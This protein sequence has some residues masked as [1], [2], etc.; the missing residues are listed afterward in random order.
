MK[1]LLRILF[2]L[3]CYL[4][5]TTQNYIVAQK[6]TERISWWAKKLDSTGLHNLYKLNDSIYRSEQPDSAS[7]ANLKKIGIKS[8]LN[9]TTQQNDTAVSG[10]QNFNYY[11][12]QMNAESFSNSDIIQ[13]LAVIRDAPKPILIHCR[14]GS[15]RTGVVMAM[16]RIIYENRSKQEALDELRNGGYGFNTIFVNI[17]KYIKKA[18][19][20]K[21]RAKLTKP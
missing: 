21:L 6:T 16:Y 9:I 11:F 18:N 4:G 2:I 14:H 15:D 13:A 12:V 20:T 8:I 19:I 17:P 7:F 5:T 3:I 10:N 1:H